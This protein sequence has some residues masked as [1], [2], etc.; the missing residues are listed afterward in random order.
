MRLSIL[1]G[2]FLTISA[3]ASAAPA[4]A[5][6][7]C[8]VGG[9]ATFAAADV[10]S[11]CG[12]ASGASEVNTLSVTTNSAGDIVFTDTNAITDGD[13]GTGCTVSAKTATCPGALAYVFDLGAGNDSATVGA[14]AS[15]GNQST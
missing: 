6:T 4:S 7:V 15:G 8:E 14:V 12:P 11:A 2:T 13:P 1:L 3:F 5:A 9:V 10:A